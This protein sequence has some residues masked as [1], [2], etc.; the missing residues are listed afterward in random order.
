MRANWKVK[1]RM[2]MTIIIN[3]ITQ[4]LVKV[5]PGLNC[6]SKEVVII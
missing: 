5:I 6:F 1:N 4:K 2:N 3:C